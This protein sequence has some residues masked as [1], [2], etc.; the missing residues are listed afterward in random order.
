MVVRDDCA[1]YGCNRSKQSDATVTVQIKGVNVSLEPCSYHY[2]LLEVM[3]PSL[4]SIGYTY[5]N[6]IE[7]RLHPAAPAPPA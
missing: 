4:Y 2:E 5:T 3:D 6:D 1:F 7:I